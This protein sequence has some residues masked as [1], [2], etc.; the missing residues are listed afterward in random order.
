VERP[1]NPGRRITVLQK[2]SGVQ[3]REAMRDRKLRM[4]IEFECRK[5]RQEFDAT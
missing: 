4:I 3:R 1:P 5:C 2:H